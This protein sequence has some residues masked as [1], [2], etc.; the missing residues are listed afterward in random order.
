MQAGAIYDFFFFFPK[1]NEIIQWHEERLRSI[2]KFKKLKH[3]TEKRPFDQVEFVFA[4]LTG[5][6][7]WIVW[8]RYICGMV[9]W[10][11][12]EEKKVYMS[13]GWL[14]RQQNKLP[15]KHFAFFVLS[16]NEAKLKVLKGN[17]G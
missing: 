14:L 8:K 1:K 16:V 2:L 3:F 17:Y 11:E 13:D 15:T 9:S 4:S 5:K 10:C 12:E 6:V 7:V